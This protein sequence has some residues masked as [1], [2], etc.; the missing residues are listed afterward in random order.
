MNI[1][2][3]L[4][5]V[6]GSSIITTVINYIFT[7]SYVIQ[8]LDKYESFQLHRNNRDWQEG[9]PAGIFEQWVL[10]LEYQPAWSQG[11]CA[12][13]AAHHISGSYAA[14]HLSI[15]GLWPNFDPVMHNGFLWPQYCV[16]AD[17]TSNFTQCD[18][19]MTEDICH[20]DQETTI[21]F[22]STIWPRHNPE[23]AYSDLADHEWAKHGSCSGMSQ[24]DYF[25][26]IE[27]VAL[28]LVT[29]MGGKLV[30][31]NIG[32]NVSHAALVKAFSQDVNNKHI[33]MLCSDKCELTDV[34]FAF[35]RTTLSSIDNDG[36]DS[37]IR[38]C[39]AG[40]HIIDWGT[41]GCH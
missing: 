29:G 24:L 39:S 17:G 27:T 7:Y 14:N 10:A 6:I 38:K 16:S 2:Y 12:D 30:T 21:R 26:I 41:E 22:N 9:A 11:K 13:S 23:Y 32:G 28:P 33:V 4:C 34:M 19:H 40:I 1:Y 31:A 36:S 5:M 20:I 8:N 15:H 18:P 37:C 35:D 3:I 25:S